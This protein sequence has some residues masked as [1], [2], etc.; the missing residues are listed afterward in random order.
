MYV[1]TY[2]QAKTCKYKRIGKVFIEKVFMEP[3]FYIYINNNLLEE[4]A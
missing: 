1:H 4:E 3:F 2:N